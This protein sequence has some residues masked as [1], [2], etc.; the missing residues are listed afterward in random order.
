MYL[1]HPVT[2]FLKRFRFPLLVLTH[3]VT[4]LPASFRVTFT[5]KCDW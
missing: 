1:T 2:R 3:L 5:A 4:D